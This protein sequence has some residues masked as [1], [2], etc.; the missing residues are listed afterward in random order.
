[1]LSIAGKGER[2]APSPVRACSR[3]GAPAAALATSKQ[4]SVFDRA[5]SSTRWYQDPLP[6]SRASERS[7]PLHILPAQT[8]RGSN[9]PICMTGRASASSPDSRSSPPMTANLVA[10]GVGV[11]GTSCHPKTPPGEKEEIESPAPIL[12][13]TP[14]EGKIYCSSTIAF[15]GPRKDMERCH[16]GVQ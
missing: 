7:I 10:R 4:K 13:T 11:E 5:T 15:P 16:R 12:Q 8:S 6:Q 9:T 14:P 2:G 3:A 1:M